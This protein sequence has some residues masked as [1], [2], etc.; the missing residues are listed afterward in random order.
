MKKQV[1]SISFLVLFVFMVGCTNKEVISNRTEK[2]ESQLETRVKELEQVI[3]KLETTIKQHE[4][5]FRMESKL[6]ELESANLLL[7]EQTVSI[8]NDLQ[9]MKELIN[10]TMDSKTAIVENAEINGG[11]LDLT[12]KLAVKVNDEDAPNG[13]R[14]EYE[15]T[16]NRKISV[17]K[18]VPI[19]L[20]ENASTPVKVSW[21]EMVN[22]KGFIQ[23]FNKNG[24]VVFISEVYIP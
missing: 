17:L 11:K 16:G 24:Q 3:A 19:Y 23:L 21:E 8:N 12:V 15:D 4:E 20:L 14:L 6:E 10:H 13:F 22:Y 5:E 2:E 1:L 18:D 7:K 9:V